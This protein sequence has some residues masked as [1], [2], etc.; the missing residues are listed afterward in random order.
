MTEADI[1]GLCTPF[2]W[3]GRTF[4]VAPRTL[5]IELM[6]QNWVQGEAARVIRRHLDRQLVEQLAQEPET[7]NQL[8]DIMIAQD[9][10]NPQ[11]PAPKEP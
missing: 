11:G 7:W 2:E 5:D 10:P 1:A 3:K 6:F 4:Q 8:L 9:F